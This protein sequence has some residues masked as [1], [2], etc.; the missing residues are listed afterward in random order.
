MVDSIPLEEFAHRQDAA[1]RVAR[2]VGVDALLV[3]GRAFY[4]RPGLLAYLTN[5][6]PPE[7][8]MVFAGPL[9]GAGHGVLL[10]PVRGEP[11]L[12]TAGVEPTQVAVADVRPVLDLGRALISALE[13]R[14]LTAA[15]VGVAGADIM[16]LSLYLDLRN[17]V[18]G[19]DWVC[20]D[21]ALNDLRRVKSVREQGLLRR[22]VAIADQAHGAAR[23]RLKP[24]VTERE[25]CAAGTAAALA[26]GADFVRYMRVHAG[27][28]SAHAFRWPQA[29]SVP[30]TE[31]DLVSL[32]VIGA[33]KGYG[34]D[35]LRTVVV[36]KPSAEQMR[37]LQ[38]VTEAVTSMVRVLRPGI[39]VDMLVRTGLAVLEEHGYARYARSFMGH[40]IGLETVEIPYLVPGE[41]TALRAGEVLCIEPGV[42]IPAWGGVSVERQVIVTEEGCEVLDQTPLMWEEGNG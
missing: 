17:G 29:R 41:E 6:F 11:V 26:G 28:D 27:V 13:E 12:F 23:A 25:L 16:P 10:L 21:A 40:G 8:T 4:D 5:Y 9:R 31:G 32:D 20:V 15:R 35:I 24:G 1:R 3:I 30:V 37:L 2:E 7:P 14:R 22:A 34:F 19:V 42:A 36:G 33:Y 18:P 39:T 38:A